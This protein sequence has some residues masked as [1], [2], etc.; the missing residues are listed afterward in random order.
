MTTKLQC[1]SCKRAR[2]RSEFF[3]KKCQSCSTFWRDV[4]V[5][6]DKEEERE[7]VAGVFNRRRGPIFSEGYTVNG[8][9]LRK[10]RMNLGIG[11]AA[12]TA[13]CS[14]GNKRR[15]SAIEEQIESV[16]V[17]EYKALYEVLLG[18]GETNL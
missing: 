15:L 17:L 18:F 14:L 2:R 11:K 3:N 9:E 5:V 4:I 10:A 13:L 16:D 8:F 12:L 7:M 6:Q 1:V